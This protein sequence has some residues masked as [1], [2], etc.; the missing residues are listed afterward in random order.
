MTFQYEGSIWLPLV[1]HA[2]KGVSETEDFLM[3]SFCV[4]EINNGAEETVGS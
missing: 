4:L 1:I 2:C 3:S